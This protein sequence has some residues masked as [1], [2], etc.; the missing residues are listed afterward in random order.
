[1]MQDILLPRPKATLPVATSM[2]KSM[3]GRCSCYQSTPDMWPCSSTL[4]NLMNREA[5]LDAHD[6]EGANE[7]ADASI[8]KY[9]GC[10]I[11]GRSPEGEVEG[12]NGHQQHIYNEAWGRTHMVFSYAGLLTKE[13][14]QQ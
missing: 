7:R 3:L 6:A 4:Q 9:V 14:A 2:Q 8:H 10:A 1:M 11:Q 13:Q 12:H 5:H